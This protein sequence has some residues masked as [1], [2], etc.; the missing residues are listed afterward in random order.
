MKTITF[1]NKGVASGII[2]TER[3]TCCDV[4]G[5]DEECPK[6]RNCNLW[7]EYSSDPKEWRKDYIERMEEMM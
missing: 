5:C 1:L 6:K 3:I 2:N 7:H 4:C